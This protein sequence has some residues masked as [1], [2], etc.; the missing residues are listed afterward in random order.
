MQNFCNGVYCEIE[1]LTRAVPVNGVRYAVTVVHPNASVDSAV[2]KSGIV[3]EID[4]RVVSRQRVK[5]PVIY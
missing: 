5:G 4:C 3:S 2:V 1:R